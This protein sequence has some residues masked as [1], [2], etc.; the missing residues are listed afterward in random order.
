MKYMLLIHQGTTPLPGTDDWNALSQEEQGKV[1]A[2]YKAVN[3]TP[4][5]TPGERMEG[6]ETA[7]T[8]RVQDGKTLTTDG[9]FAE[10]KEA[11]GGYGVLRG[12]R[13]RRRHR[14]RREDP[15]REHGRRGRGPADRGVIA[16]LDQAFRDQW[17]RVLAALIGFLGDFDLAE[18]A[19]QEAFA[20]AAERW[21]REGVP[22][23][24]GAWLVTTARNRAIDRIRRERTA[25]GEAAP[26]RGP[27][28][29]GGHDGRHD[30]PRRAARARLHLLPPRARAPTRRSR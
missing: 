16:S 9:P 28:G 6:P 24:P 13:P 14:A 29:G 19:A 8:V 3:E 23:N 27:R 11:I 22:S 4:G 1:Y 26:A 21:P 18:E 17:G 12:R 5:F 30:L 10:L 25:R 2:G 15:R 7:T 20:I